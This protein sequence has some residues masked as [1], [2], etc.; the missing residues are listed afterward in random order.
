M[1]RMWVLTVFTETDNSPAISGRDRFVGR[2]RSTRSSL[3][4]S[5]SIP[6]GEGSPS[7][8]TDDPRIT[9]RM[10]ASSAA[11][12]VS[13]HGPASSSFS[14]PV[15]ANGRISRSASDRSSALSVAAAIRPCRL[16]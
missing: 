5:C 15:I 8:G 13:C 6:A 1:L 2:Y 10:V 14:E 11:C 4:L 16:C 9:S 3:G 7:G 12:A